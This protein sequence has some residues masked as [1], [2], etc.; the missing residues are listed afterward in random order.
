LTDINAADEALIPASAKEIEV[1]VL[2]ITATKD[3]IGIPI[4][5]I[6][7]TQPYAKNYRLRPIEAGHFLQIESSEET[8]KVLEEFFIEVLKNSTKHY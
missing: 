4:N 2:L 6:N 8:N 5:A 1:P 7:G 3:P